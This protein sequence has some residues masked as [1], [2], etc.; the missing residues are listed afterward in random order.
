M[1]AFTLIDA[2]SFGSGALISLA[3]YFVPG[4]EELQKNKKQL[5]ILITTL[6]T[7]LVIGAFSCLGWSEAAGLPSITCN[8]TGWVALIVAWFEV[9]SGVVV[10]YTSS[11]HLKK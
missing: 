2:I 5:A 1:Q 11:K 9:L 6:V 3:V 10:T 8:E 7:A 4:F